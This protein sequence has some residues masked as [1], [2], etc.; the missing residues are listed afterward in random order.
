MSGAPLEKVLGAYGSPE[1]EFSGGAEGSDRPAAGYGTV[2]DRIDLQNSISR[3][4]PSSFEE[5][6]E[7]SPDG[8]DWKKSTRRV[9]RFLRTFSCASSMRSSPSKTTVS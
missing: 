2:M 9:L 3:C 8:P 5:F 1:I 6:R 7:I 4:K